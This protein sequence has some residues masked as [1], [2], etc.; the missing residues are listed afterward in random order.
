METIKV[1]TIESVSLSLIKTNPPSVLISVKAENMNSNYSKIRLE[2]FVYVHPPL[3]GIWEFDMVGDVPPITD[4]LVTRVGATLDWKAPKDA[5]GV[6]V[7]GLTNSK[8]ALLF[9]GG[10]THTTTNKAGIQVIKAEAVIDAEPMKPPVTLHVNLTFNSNNHGFHNLVMAKPQGINPK[11]LL[12]KLTDEPE[13]IFITNPRST[14]Y[15]QVLT[16]TNQFT[17]VQ[18]IYE[19]DSIVSINHIPILV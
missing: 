5:K 9:G 12:L 14:A 13:D 17:G 16:E 1:H 11:I 2:P 7:Y 8:T 4:Q 18:I 3:N 10:G 15:S 19:G 6:K